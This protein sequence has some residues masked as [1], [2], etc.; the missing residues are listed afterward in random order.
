MNNTHNK[1]SRDGI[2]ERFVK[3]CAHSCQRL[4]NAIE[5]ARDTVVEEFRP[6]N[7]LQNRMLRLA[8]NEAEA[9]AWQTDYPELVFPT[10]AQEKA[11]AVKAWAQHQEIVLR[12]GPALAFA[13]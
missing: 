1:I 11:E 9:I 13:A 2:G 5:Q 8:L 12:G 10:L 7:G 4:L 6:S 3:A